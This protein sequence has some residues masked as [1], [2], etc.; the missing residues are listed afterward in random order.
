MII[1]QKRY[2][3]LLEVIIALMLVALCVIPLLVPHVYL[4]KQQQRFLDEVELDNMVNLLYS[5]VIVRLYANEIPWGDISS[6]RG[7]KTGTVFEINDDMIAKAGYN[8][9]LPFK[10]TYWF[11]EEKRKPKKEGPFTYYLLNLYFKF[12]YENPKITK[13]PL[14]Y[15][16]NVFLL[17]NLADEPAEISESDEEEME[18]EDENSDQEE[19]KK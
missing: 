18:E 16:Y 13:E 2:T 7:D 19:M 12:S 6:R 5:D 11:E 14:V 15:K 4:L 17:R 9:F 1:K 10:G 8:K 3:L